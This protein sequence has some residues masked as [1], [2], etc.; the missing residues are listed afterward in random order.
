MTHKKSA[1]RGISMDSDGDLS[2][3][4]MHR[5]CKKAGADR[6]SKSAADEMAKVLGEV[7]LRIAEEAIVYTMH[8]GRK[9]VKAR[10]I[11]IASRKV[12]KQ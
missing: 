8:A 10:D 11:E 12:L 1:A 4:A 5:I 6:V 2:V 9:T 3:A 7:G